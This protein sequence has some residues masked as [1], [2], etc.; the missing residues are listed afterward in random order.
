MLKQDLIQAAVLNCIT[1]TLLKDLIQAA[2]LNCITVTLLMG[3]HRMD[4]WTN[5][6]MDE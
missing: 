6:Q 4:G 1:V 3:R 5:Q 2:V